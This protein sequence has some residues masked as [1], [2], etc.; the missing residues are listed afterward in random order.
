MTPS[1][2]R[3]LV[4]RLAVLFVPALLIALISGCYPKQ[5]KSQKAVTPKVTV[6]LATADVSDVQNVFETT[7]RTARVPIKV[8]P[9]VRG[10]L[11][12][13]NFKPGDIVE[14]G[15]VLYKI[16]EFDYKAAVDRAEADCEITQA[17]FDK[18]Q[19]DYNRQL[20]MKAKGP[21][22]TTDDDVEKA[23]AQ[24]EEAKGNVKAAHVRLEQAKKDLERTVIK[25]PCR[26]KINET[27]VEAG[28]L[29][30][31]S[32]GTEVLLTT[33]MPM[34]PMY[35]Y[36]EITD[37]EFGH[38]T[39]KLL[40]EVKEV[41]GD[42]YDPS[43][44]ISN[45]NLNTL[46]EENELE[47]E[48][49]FEMRLPSDP[50]GEFPHK[51]RI[52]YFENNVNRNTG[53]ITLRGSIENAE[54]RVFPGYICKV[55]IPGEIIPGAVLVEEKALCYDL[56]DTYLWVIGGDGKP[57]R[58]LVTAGK[59]YG[60]DKRIITAGLKGGEKYVIDG[61]QYVQS[62]C[63]IEELPAAEDQAPSADSQDRAE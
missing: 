9:R 19:S 2:F 35:V 55:R 3:R 14:E 13:V 1:V 16:E 59:Q 20:G 34:D 48:I 12:E 61:T 30:D 25:S 31:G 27:K 5:D 24:L 43:V 7:G 29:V 44:P 15:A 17:Q 42:K 56:S 8:V 38:L 37:T 41:L 60:L 33:I 22:I 26:G 18:A 40:Q 54:Y 11:E 57:Y 47:S 4:S 45:Q 10:T 62:G 6:R 28:T 46:L 39:E 53:T 32:A 58:Q 21:G 23:K 51:G 49:E 63:E 36:F 52:T 50:P